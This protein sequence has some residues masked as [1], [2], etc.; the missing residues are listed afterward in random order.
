M[1]YLTSLKFKRGNI[2]YYLLFTACLMLIVY[3]CRYGFANIDESFYLTIPY[4]LYQGDALFLDEWNLSQ[5]SSF[6]LYPITA[7]YLRITGTTEGIILNFRYIYVFIHAVVSLILYYRLRSENEYGAV[8]ASLVILLYV[9]FNI[10]A[11]SYNSMGID[12]MILS[13]AFAFNCC[14]RAQIIASG[15]FFACAV[16]CC[17]YL[18]ALYVIL[19]L[20]AII[21]NLRQSDKTARI[22]PGKSFFWWSVG[23]AGIALLFVGFVFSRMTVKQMIQVLPLILNDP[24]HVSRPLWQT[25]SSYFSS[26]L[27]GSAINTTYVITA[28][29]FLAAIFDRHRNKR[30]YLYFALVTV[31]FVA[32]LYYYTFKDPYINFLMLPLNIYILFLLLMTEKRELQLLNKKALYIFILPGLGYT[33][34]VHLASNQGI[35]NISSASCI[36]LIGCAVMLGGFLENEMQNADIRRILAATAALVIAAVEIGAVSYIRYKTVFWE[37]SIEEQTE[38]ISDGVEK[39]I[40]V[41]IGKYEMYYNSYEEVNEYVGQGKVLYL[42]TEPWLYLMTENENAAPSAWPS[43]GADNQIEQLQVYYAINPDKKAEQIVCEKYQQE[44][45]KQVFDLESYTSVE[46]E[47]N[48]IVYRLIE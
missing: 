22:I 40:F 11:M 18:A 7:V 4:R 1:D 41:S 3:K 23:I 32:Q 46:T 45:L 5:M 19:L 33:M 15:C 27:R 43:G 13:A 39:N 37:P 42:L 25:V 6:L 47:N 31:V 21:C 34:C 17:P 20:L 26:Y 44:T 30:K 9:P 10:M 28:I 29:L 38:Y 35:Y 24:E 14:K 8:L 36:I 12:S 16:L 2:I 48:H